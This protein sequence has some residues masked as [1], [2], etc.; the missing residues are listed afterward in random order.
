MTIR[1]MHKYKQQT[2]THRKE[3]KKITPN[4]NRI[5]NITIVKEKCAKS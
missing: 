2:T 1:K 4:N 5:N 3:G